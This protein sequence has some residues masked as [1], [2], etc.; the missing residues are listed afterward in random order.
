MGQLRGLFLRIV[1]VVLA[2]L[3]SAIGPT[4]AAERPAVTGVRAADHAGITR[5]VL[6]IS[7]S[8]PVESESPDR[9]GPVLG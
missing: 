3:P 8:V 1:V 5:F 9:S 6:D 4:A 2:G 7:A